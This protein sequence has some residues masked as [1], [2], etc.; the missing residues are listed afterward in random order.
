MS[1]P[2]RLIIVPY[3]LLRVWLCWQ[4]AANPSLLANLGNAGRFRRIAG[5]VPT[6][7]CRKP[8]TLN[9]LYSSLPNLTS[10]EN[11][12]H[13][14]EA[15]RADEVFSIHSVFYSALVQALKEARENAKP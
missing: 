1:D 9:A 11:L 8:Q 12:G 6:S 2:D 14:R 7:S 4:S 10:R 3:Q 15:S 5:K 13:S